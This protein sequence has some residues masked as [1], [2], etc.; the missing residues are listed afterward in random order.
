MF[1]DVLD[2]I[3]IIIKQSNFT[4]STQSQL[5]YCIWKEKFK[6][7]DQSKG[8]ELLTFPFLPSNSI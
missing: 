5:Q 2:L 8:L 4:I 3:N 1:S 6:H 7:K